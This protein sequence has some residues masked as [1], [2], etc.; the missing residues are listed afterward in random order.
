MEPSAQGEEYLIV[1]KGHCHRIKILAIVEQRLLDEL[2]VFQLLGRFGSGHDIEETGI[3][4][5]GHIDIREQIIDV[6]HE[7]AHHA[8]PAMMVRVNQTRQYN[9]ACGINHLGTSRCDVRLDGRDAI[10]F[11][12]DIPGDEIGDIGI[13]RYDGAALEEGAYGVKHGVFHSVA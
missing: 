11:D 13:H 12:E 2:P 9:V 10:A 6:R 8:K 4:D 5:G 7:P 1:A 3:P